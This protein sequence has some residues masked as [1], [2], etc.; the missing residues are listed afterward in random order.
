[1]TTKKNRL[2]FT[3]TAVIVLS[4]TLL[5]VTGIISAVL[6]LRSGEGIRTMINERMLDISNTAAAMMDGDALTGM[7]ADDIGSPD[8]E[9]GMQTLRTFYD[10]TE[11]EYIYCI[12]DRGNG[13]YVFGLDPSDD[14]GSFD[15]PIVT[16]PALVEAF[17]GVSSVDREAY[18][19][20]WG[21]FYSSYS[22]VFNSAGEVACVVAVDFD[23]NWYNNRLAQEVWIVLAVM[24]VALLAGIGVTLIVTGRVRKQLRRV[25]QAA[26]KLG[27]DVEQLARQI[28]LD[29]GGAPGE[30]TGPDSETHSAQKSDIEAIRQQLHKAQDR[31]KEY[32]SYTLAQSRRDLMTGAGNRNAYLEKTEDLNTRIADGSAA[33]A[34]GIFDINNLKQINDIYGHETGDGIIVQ[35]AG[36]LAEVF[37]RDNIFRIGGDEFI[38]VMEGADEDG[39]SRMS[40]QLQEALVRA[41][42]RPVHPEAELAMS[43][44]FAVFDPQRDANFLAIFRRADQGMYSNKESFY[45]SEEVRRKL[46]NMNS[47]AAR[48]RARMQYIADH[49][50]NAIAKGQIRAWLQPIVRLVNNRICAEEALAR[51]NDPE[52]GMISPAEFIPALEEARLAYKLDLHMV[53]EVARFLQKKMKDGIPLAPISVNLSRTDFDACDMVEEITKRMDSAGVSRDL[54]R[55][56][57]TE[58]VIGSDFDFMKHQIERFGEKGF[59]VW[60]DDFGSGYSSLDLLQSIHFDTIKLDMRFMREFDGSDRSRIILTELVS[61]AMSL[62]T[63]TIVEGVETEEQVRF[64][65]EIGAGKLQGYFFCPPISQETLMEK[66]STGDIRIGLEN[67]GET[68]Y[69]NSVS[70]VNLQDPS[71]ITKT[72]ALE[73]YGGYFRTLPMAVLEVGEDEAVIIRV[74]RS[75]REFLKR[76]IGF[77]MEEGQQVVLPVASLESRSPF[78]E[79][80]VRCRDTGN[81]EI[82]RETLKDG[83]NIQAFVRQIAKNPVTGKA[84]VA[85]IVLA[86]V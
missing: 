7:T 67:P 71:M 53:E 18:E 70:K 65:R 48:N 61:M 33:F 46:T 1:M 9:K 77:E 85:L 31:L 22:P 28:S 42:R 86:V 21:V 45:R 63:N 16:T 56:E 25:N 49:L 78:T 3:M 79:A 69:Y 6:F 73:D 5:I 62:G 19:D 54:L 59:R 36:V 4:A 74:N 2:S 47:S 57:I 40:A 26:G 8:F 58:S 52:Q 38:A 27:T 14:P 17:R 51:W 10:N 84:A 30:D 11:L 83:K 72:E 76:Y 24:L 68:E 80:V 23:A 34:I 20:E 12:Y 64:L 32:I 13:R 75:Y 60:M 55:I 81:W 15:D 82:L 35:A 66:R 29:S 39:I 44:G 37:G 43:K 41:N 50:E